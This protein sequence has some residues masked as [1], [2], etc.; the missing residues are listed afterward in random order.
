MTGSRRATDLSTTPALMPMLVNGWKFSASS[1]SAFYFASIP[2]SSLPR[3]V[4]SKMQI[5]CFIVLSVR[6]RCLS[7]VYEPLGV[8][9]LC[10]PSAPF[11]VRYC[12]WHLSLQQLQTTLNLFSRLC[13]S[14]CRESGP[15]FFTWPLLL[16][17][18]LR[19]SSV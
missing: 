19:L 6:L 3:E 9:P 10:P 11:S 17:C 1:Q 18:S 15:N 14:T 4:C 8:S 7:L 5:Q 12:H 2:P 16:T 13:W